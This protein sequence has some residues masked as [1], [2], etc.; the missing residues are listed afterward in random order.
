MRL[1]TGLVFGTLGAVMT[2]VLMERADVIPVVIGFASG[3]V[4]AQI[5]EEPLR[6]LSLHCRASGTT[7]WLITLPFY[8]LSSAL[9]MCIGVISGNIPEPQIV[10]VPV[11]PGLSKGARWL[12]S[13]SVTLTPGTITL[14]ADEENYTVLFIPG[15]N[16]DPHNI[17]S[18]FESSLCGREESDER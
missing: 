17:A 14:E 18:P 3:F 11:R 1:K 2:C 16:D 15:S 6:E 13:N 7:R 12:V 5:V 10:K 4:C 8:V 9:R